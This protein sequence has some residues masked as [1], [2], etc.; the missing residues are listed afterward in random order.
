MLD[1]PLMQ[2]LSAIDWTTFGAADIS[3]DA[4]TV[5]VAGDSYNGAYSQKSFDL[6]GSSASV[7]VVAADPASSIDLMIVA[8]TP[9]ADGTPNAFLFNINGGMLTAKWQVNYRATVLRQSVYDSRAHGYLRI[10]STSGSVTFSTSPDG[11]RWRKFASCPASVLVAGPVFIQ[12]MG[13]ANSA[14]GTSTTTWRNVCAS[15]TASPVSGVVTAG[16]H[17]SL[18][19]SSTAAPIAPTAIETRQKADEPAGPP[20]RPA[21]VMSSG[22]AGADPAPASLAAEGIRSVAWEGYAWEIGNWG[23]N[24]EGGPDASQVTVDSLGNMILSIGRLPDGRYCGAE[25][26]SAR[27]DRALANNPS[28][29]GYGRYRWV[30]SLSQTLAPT[31]VLGLF[32]YWAQDKGGP[33]GQCEIDVELSSWSIAG[34]P[35]FIQA[36]YYANDDTDIQWAVPPY[37]VMVAG[38]QMKLQAGPKTVTAEFE[39]MPDH[40]TYNVWHSAD[41]CGPPGDTVT[42]REGQRYRFQQPYGGNDFA[43]TAHI[44]KTGGQQVIMNLWSQ[45]QTI[46]VSQEVVIHSFTYTEPAFR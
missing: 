35:E 46:Q 13:S 1:M 29:W 26:D 4:L 12:L 42:I 9:G 24:G 28:T 45:D 32:T 44:P 23:T 21:A 39:W 7:Q 20:P 14:P 10:A 8:G 37:H 5:K 16:H 40:I 3:E 38:S 31:L 34:A 11:V 36:G 22:F 43:G 17:D 30:L 18:D 6:D 41:T 2:G 25:V 27:G 33:P 15:Y 19:P